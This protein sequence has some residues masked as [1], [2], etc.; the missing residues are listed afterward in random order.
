MKSSKQRF[1]GTWIPGYQTEP[2]EEVKEDGSKMTAP[3]EKVQRGQ[4]KG[5]FTRARKA[6]ADLIGREAD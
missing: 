4:A 6:L 1:L 2:V 5:T 3:E